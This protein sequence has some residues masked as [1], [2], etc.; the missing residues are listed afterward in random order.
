MVCFRGRR[1]T[2]AEVSVDKL[3]ELTLGEKVIA[4]S[5]I[6]L[7]IDSFLPWF[8]KDIRTVLGTGS[9]SKNGWGQFL[10]LLAIL[11]GLAMAVVAVLPKVAEV[12][13][14][15]KLGNLSWGQVHMIAGIVALALI[16]LQL[17][18]GKDYHG[19][20]ID[21]SYGLFIGVVFGAGLAYGGFLKSREATAPS[22]PSPPSPPS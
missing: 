8:K 18:I 5:G 22:P 2:A 20:T 10:T 9:I 1:S 17:A 14:P 11:I 15:E 4:A 6:L 12:N 3:K 13:F 7:F 21:R 19:L 16:V